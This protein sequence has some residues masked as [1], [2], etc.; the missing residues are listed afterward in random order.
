MFAMKFGYKNAYRYPGG[1]K[2]WVEADYPVE[3]VK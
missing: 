2:A 1:I 3:N